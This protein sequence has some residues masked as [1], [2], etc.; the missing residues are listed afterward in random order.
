LRDIVPTK[1][2]L[3]KRR[4]ISFEEQMRVSEC[5]Q[6][7]S[8]DHPFFVLYFI[9]IFMVWCVLLVRHCYSFTP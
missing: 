7:E 3:F 1:V 9:W 6:I 4:I 8:T 5:G 2:N